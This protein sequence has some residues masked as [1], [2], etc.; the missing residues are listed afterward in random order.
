[1]VGVEPTQIAQSSQ[2]WCPSMNP[3]S[4]QAEHVAALTDATNDFR[5]WKTFVVVVF[6]DHGSSLDYFC[7][8]LSL[9]AIPLAN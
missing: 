6:S 4:Q 8:N 3:L 9:R 1:M 5:P 2:S 7:S